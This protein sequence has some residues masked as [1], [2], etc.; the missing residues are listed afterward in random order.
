ML[1]FLPGFAYMGI[2][3]DELACPRHPKPRLRVAAG[4]V[5]IAGRQTGIYP[6]DSPGGWQIIGRTSLRLFDPTREQPALFAPGDRVR[7]VPVET[8]RV[9]AVSEREAGEESS[10]SGPLPGGA[11]T[12][13]VVQPGLF[14]TVQ[15]EGR[16]GFQSIGVSVCGAMDVHAHRLAN[17]CVGNNRSAATLEV[18][19]AGPHLRFDAPATV[20]ITGADL[21]PTLDGAA[22]PMGTMIAC[23]A[24]AVLQ[25]GQR[26]SG[27]RAYVAFDGG[28]AVPTVLGSSATHMMTR[29]GG[30]NGRQLRSG[31]VLTLHDPVSH[32]QS[33]PEIANIPSRAPGGARLRVIAGPQ[34]AIFGPEAFDALQRS[35]F[36]IAP[37]SNRMGYRLEGGAEIRRTDA[38]EMISD[39]T[40]TGAVQVPPSGDPILLMADRQTIGGYA[41]IATVITAD[42]PVAAQLAPGDWVEFE[43]CTREQA[44]AA[45][46]EQET[47]LRAL[48]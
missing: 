19:I 15:D 29:I 12:V 33:A 35:R 36:F 17:A 46:I 28:I 32:T 25:F 3:D 38:T 40:F 6:F 20:A 11:R 45:L 23:A 24:G 30:V 14:T 48:A 13:T 8:G 47:R 7:F 37:Q 39:A 18:T 43:L 16:W 34:D 5:G 42:L 44:V 2:V 1:G 9:K 21:Q 41:Q 31:D 22:C 26:R 10:A 27:T 4:S